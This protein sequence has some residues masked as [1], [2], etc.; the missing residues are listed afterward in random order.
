MQGLFVG[1]VG[2]VVGGAIGFGLWSLLPDAWRA[3]RAPVAI[4]A[5][6]LCGLF[7]SKIELPSRQTLAAVERTLLAHPDLGELMTAWKET[8]P[9][10]F[11]DFVALAAEQGDADFAEAQNDPRY[12]EMVAIG[13]RRLAYLSDEQAV[14]RFRISRDQMLELRQ[15]NPALCARV[16]FN[17]GVDYSNPPFSRSLH[18]RFLALQANALR[19]SPTGA[20][21]AMTEAE[22]QSAAQG[23]FERIH[24]VVGEDVSLLSPDATVE[25][26]E[27]RFC[28]VAAEY[29]NQVSLS[30]EPGR[31]NAGMVRMQHGAP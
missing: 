18:R 30:L 11:A 9:S 2:A 19:S 29:F 25:G 6:V 8:D 12:L 17:R 21:Q 13:G 15:T 26:S 7:A 27:A 5:A 28:E 10:A 4:V 31:L 20:P 16:F 23:I 3:A 22:V 1:A 24:A 14:E